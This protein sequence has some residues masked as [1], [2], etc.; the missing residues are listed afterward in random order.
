MMM[1]LQSSNKRHHLFPY[2]PGF[3]SQTSQFT[4][5]SRKTKTLHENPQ[6]TTTTDHQNLHKFIAS[7]SAH[8]S[9][10]FGSSS[11]LANF[12]FT[13]VSSKNIS[14]SNNVISEPKDA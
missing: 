12:P 13:R 6:F 8:I 3:F 7:T 11:R 2:A 10:F 1:Q 9:H 5:A 4:R 14:S